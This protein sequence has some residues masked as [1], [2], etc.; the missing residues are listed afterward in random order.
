MSA[1][2]PSVL[3]LLCLCPA[4]HRIIALAGEAPPATVESMTELAKASLEAAIA[5]KTIK[6]VCEL[7][8]APR[9]QWSFEV[10]ELADRTLA[11][12][13]PAL[14]ASEAEQIATQARFKAEAR[15]LRN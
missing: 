15:A 7:C 5:A 10:A 4:Q 13:M 2:R 9:D 8:K 11:E 3:L 14:R 1:P 12:V 6:P